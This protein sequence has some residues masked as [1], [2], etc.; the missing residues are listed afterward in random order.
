[1]KEIEERRAATPSEEMYA[2][3]DEEIMQSEHTDQCV[4]VQH[5]PSNN[6]NVRSSIDVMDFKKIK[7]K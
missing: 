3:E 6:K 1:M 7:K 2:A 4:N 5:H